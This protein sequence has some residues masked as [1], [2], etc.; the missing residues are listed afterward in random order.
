MPAFAKDYMRNIYNFG[1][2]G[3]WAPATPG[4]GVPAQWWMDISQ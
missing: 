3:P 1:V 2:L 4:N